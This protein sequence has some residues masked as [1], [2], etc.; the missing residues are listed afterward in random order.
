L[1]TLSS[2]RDLSEKGIQRSYTQFLSQQ[3][4]IGASQDAHQLENNEKKRFEAASS[5]GARETWLD[6]NQEEA[7]DT[8]VFFV[9]N[10]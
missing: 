5:W 8:I 4:K 7:R 2:T 9:K 10:Q 6:T 1:Q 3:H